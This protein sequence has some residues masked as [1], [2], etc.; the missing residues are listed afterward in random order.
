MSSLS[1]DESAES[2]LFLLVLEYGQTGPSSIVSPTQQ[3]VGGC[4][5][6]FVL[7]KMCLFTIILCSMYVSW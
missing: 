4:D 3:V 7:K 5:R 2:F 6:C 1:Q